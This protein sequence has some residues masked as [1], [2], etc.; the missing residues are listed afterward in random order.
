M[1]SE[2]RLGHADITGEHRVMHAPDNRNYQNRPPTMPVP[3]HPMYQPTIYCWVPHVKIGLRQ[4]SDRPVPV[5]LDPRPE[6]RICGTCIG[7]PAACTSGINWGN[8][9]VATAPNTAALPGTWTGD[10][11]PYSVYAR[12][13][14]VETA[15][16]HQL[17][18]RDKG[19]VQDRPQPTHPSVIT[20]RPMR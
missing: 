17:S 12:N 7:R 1:D 14:D 9:N 16:Q 8:G 2:T 3:L 4:F 18:D 11:G 10:I 5:A 15:M 19:P 13:I 6:T 20:A